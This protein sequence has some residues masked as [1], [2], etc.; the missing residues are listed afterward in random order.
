M[1]IVTVLSATAC[2]AV[3][4]LVQMAQAEIP[5]DKIHPIHHRAIGPRWRP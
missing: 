2:A 3:A 1:T 4:E 5:V